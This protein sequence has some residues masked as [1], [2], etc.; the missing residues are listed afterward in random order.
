MTRMDGMC[1]QNS[2]APAVRQ[3]GGRARRSSLLWVLVVLLLS[4]GV[5]VH[6]RVQTPSPP[7]L[8]P[9][10]DA[11][12]RQQITALYPAQLPEVPQPW[13]NPPSTAKIALGEALFF[14]PN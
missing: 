3:A 13:F 11:A 14:D 12:L 8:T 4:G 5:A 1:A 6:L 2:Q 10:D 7:G 9:G